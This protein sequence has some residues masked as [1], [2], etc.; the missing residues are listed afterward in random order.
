MRKPYHNRIDYPRQGV[1]YVCYGPDGHRGPCA[2]WPI[3]TWYWPLVAIWNYLTH[4]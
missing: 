1:Y 4:K 2:M 3:R